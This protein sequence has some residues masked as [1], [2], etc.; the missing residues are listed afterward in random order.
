MK[1]KD[2][3]VDNV[4]FLHLMKKHSED[5][6]YLE[7]Q[8]F[9]EQMRK[10]GVKKTLG[11]YNVLLRTYGVTRNLDLLRSTW[12]EFKAIRPPIQPS[13]RTFWYLLQGGLG[14]EFHGDFF[15]YFDRCR[16]ERTRVGIPRR[17]WTCAFHILSETGQTE[18][19]LAF[20][21]EMLS[22]NINPFSPEWTVILRSIATTGNLDL[23]LQLFDTAR[24]TKQANFKTYFVVAE[25]LHKANDS[26][27]QPILTEMHSKWLNTGSIPFN[28][29]PK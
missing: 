18:K 6:N 26:R 12:N 5:G 10:E 21:N 27:A 13:A 9:S 22:K 15:K 3:I 25:A 19:L 8:R 14:K 23:L 4:P 7:V 16:R 11:V 1:R 29:P 28:P 2:L 24:K 17:M 20:L